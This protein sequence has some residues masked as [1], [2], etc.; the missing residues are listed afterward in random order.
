MAA[1]LLA[2]GL[3]VEDLPESGRLVGC[4]GERIRQSLDEI[5]RWKSI[6][7]M[8][9]DSSDETDWSAAQPTDELPLAPAVLALLRLW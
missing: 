7:K 1:R 5:M 4:V 3:R 8:S 9:A 6:A 2:D